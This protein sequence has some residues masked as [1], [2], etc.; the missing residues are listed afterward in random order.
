LKTLRG[1]GIFLAQFIGDEAPFNSLRAMAEWAAGLGYVGVQLPTGDARIFDLALAAQSQTYCEEIAGICREA[2]VVITELST[3]LQGQ[4]IAVHPSFDELFDAF[5]PRELRGRPAERQAWA[6][7][8]LLLA[9]RASQRLGLTAHATFSGALLWPM[10]YPWPQRPPGLVDAGFSEL[11][12]RWRPILERFD[13]VGVDVCYEI[14]P[15]EDLHDGVTFERF[16]A[17][18]GGHPRCCMLYDPSHLILQGIDYLAYIDHYH[19]RIRMFHV[20]DA[21]FRPNGRTGVYGGY[22]PWVERAGRFRSLGD[23]QVDFTAVFSKFAQYDFSGWAVVEWECVLKHPED[24]AREGA[25]FVR[26][27]IIRVT[28]KAFDDFAAVP[29]DAQANRR[30]LGL[31]H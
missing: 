14:H 17:A 19:A 1:P 21:E 22:L 7:E 9:A 6:V 12:R 29:L 25:K 5:A 2:G 28:D 23:G 10:F 27:H 24:G 30:L 18:V 15:G 16:L 26:E 4:L 31:D 8:Q 11:A 3:H 20:K 13:E